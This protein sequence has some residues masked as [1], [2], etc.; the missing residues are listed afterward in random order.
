MTGPPSRLRF[1][2][3]RGAAQCAARQRVR[4]D[5]LRPVHA[6]DPPR[7]ARACRPLVV[8]GRRQE[9]MRPACES[10]RAALSSSRRQVAF[11]R[12]AVPQLRPAR[13]YDFDLLADITPIEYCLKSA[14]YGEINL[15]QNCDLRLWRKTQD[16]R[17]IYATPDP[18]RS[19][20]WWNF[21]QS[22]QL[23][24]HAIILRQLRSVAG[25]NRFASEGC[26]ASSGSNDGLA[27]FSSCA[28]NMRC[29]STSACKSRLTSGSVT[30]RANRR[31]RS[32]RPRKYAAVVNIRASCGGQPPSE[33]SVP[34]AL[35]INEWAKYA[36][37][38][39]SRSVVGCV[40]ISALATL[41]ASSN[42][43]T[44]G[45]EPKPL[46]CRKQHSSITPPPSPNMKEQMDGDEAVPSVFA[47]C[48]SFFYVGRQNMWTIAYP[49]RDRARHPTP[50]YEARLFR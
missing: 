39:L 26:S 37:I 28:A 8:G 31:F 1:A 41:A 10:G 33:E 40:T 14:C 20:S 32:A 50:A 46:S 30:S 17:A 3:P 9:G 36:A 24:P 25:R 15:R 38:L 16:N 48:A 19:R 6:G 45:S 34:D 4:L 13:T 44:E 29:A 18:R 2:T 22:K 11:H 49:Q 42:S 12:V 5:R 43:K 7:R 21:N 27:C 47:V 23:V 35:P